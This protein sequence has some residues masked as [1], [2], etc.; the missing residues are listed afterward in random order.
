MAVEVSK[1]EMQFM[2]TTNGT[3]LMYISCIPHVYLVNEHMVYIDVRT[4]K[5]MHAL[6]GSHC[7]LKQTTRGKCIQPLCFRSRELEPAVMAHPSSLTPFEQRWQPVHTGIFHQLLSLYPPST[8]PPPLLFF[9]IFICA[10]VQ[11]YN[12]FYNLTDVWQWSC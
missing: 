4:H 2:E 8:A 5:R 7:I 3:Y 9:L 6:K 11:H 10:D 1:K 12:W